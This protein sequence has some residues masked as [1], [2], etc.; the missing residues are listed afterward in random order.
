MLN[1]MELFKTLIKQEKNIEFLDIYS[2][3]DRT[4]I[5]YFSC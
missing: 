2:F 4:D 5:V 1:L 3:F